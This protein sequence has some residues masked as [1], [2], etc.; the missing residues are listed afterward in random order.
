[1]QLNADLWAIV[2]PD[3]SIVEDC[4][5]RPYVYESCGVATS[6]AG[7]VR[8]RNRFGPGLRVVRVRLVE[9]EGG[10]DAR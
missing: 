9:I 8:L 4:G 10:P 5:C 3:G 2:T 1:M 6:N 7:S